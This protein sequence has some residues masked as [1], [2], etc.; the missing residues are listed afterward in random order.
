MPPKKS[1][2][3]EAPVRWPT[4]IM[5]MLGGM[6][7]PRA[8]PAAWNAAAKP[9]GYP[10]RRIAGIITEP[11]AAVE[12]LELPETAAKPIE[13]AMET[14]GSAA[15]A[16]LTSRSIRRA[17]PET[18]INSPAR[19]KSGTAISAHESS[20]AN[21]RCAATSSGIVRSVSSA[22]IPPRPTANATGTPSAS[23]TSRTASRTPVI[24]A[25]LLPL[26]FR[27][28]PG[29][30]NPRTRSLLLPWD[31]PTRRRR[32]ARGAIRPPA[33]RDRAT[34]WR[35]PAPARSGAPPRRAVGSRRRRSPPTKPP[36]ARTP[37]AAPAGGSVRRGAA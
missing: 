11:T 9:A 36:P 27:R 28:L 18:D 37:S 32:P 3:M 10:R 17:M 12:A 26:P 30:R 1:A 31:R 29:R 14:T 25:P 15:G 24:A 19:M 4:T 33:R 6:I 34:P 8:P 20:A 22:A 2:A 35:R 16:R 13:E 23:R 5:M 7:G 21:A